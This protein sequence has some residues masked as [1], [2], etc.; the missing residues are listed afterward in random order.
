M[1]IFYDNLW[2]PQEVAERYGKNANIYMAGDLFLADYICETQELLR[3]NRIH[4]AEIPNAAKQIVKL[5]EEL[6]L[7]LGRL[8]N[9]SG[10]D[11][12]GVFSPIKYLDSVCITVGQHLEQLVE[13]YGDYGYSVCFPQQQ[14]RILLPVF[15]HY[16][17]YKFYERNM[18]V[19]KNGEVKFLMHVFKLKAIMAPSDIRGDFY[20]NTNDTGFLEMFYK[21]VM[22]LKAGEKNWLN[23][24]SK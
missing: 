8:K 19:L 11:R 21:A 6:K 1:D 9:L 5:E 18:A 10:L 7:L 3:L 17:I 20:W 12:T 2:Y 16:H 24:N 14:K 22:Q 13:D 23:E 4:Q 15:K